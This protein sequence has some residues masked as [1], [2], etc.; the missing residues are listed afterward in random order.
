MLF[1]RDN[2]NIKYYVAVT[3]IKKFPASVGMIKAE[4]HIYSRFQNTEA[5]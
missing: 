3:V 4:Y 5:N 2:I 1:A